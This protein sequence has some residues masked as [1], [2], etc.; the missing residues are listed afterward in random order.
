MRKFIYFLLAFLALLGC[1]CGAIALYGCYLDS[2][3][4]HN[5]HK[6][7]IGMSEDEVVKILGNPTSR[8]I[9]DIPGTYWYYRTDLLYSLI[10]DN[11]YNVGY[12]VVKI[13][14]DGKV[15]KVYELP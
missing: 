14:R 2:H 9:S 1:S 5:I 13:S 3:L 4:R 11:P 8:A 7:E 12:S 6:I 15:E 10:D